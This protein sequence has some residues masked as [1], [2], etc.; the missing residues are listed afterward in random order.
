MKYIYDVV[1]TVMTKYLPQANL[2]AITGAQETVI[3]LYNSD[4]MEF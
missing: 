3:Y 2:F 1:D 4:I